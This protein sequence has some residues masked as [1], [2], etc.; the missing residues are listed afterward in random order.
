LLLNGAGNR[1]GRHF[2][3]PDRFD[4][5]RSV[6]RRLSFGYGAHFCVA[7]LARI[8]GQVALREMLR[9]FP[10]WEVDYD[11]AEMVHT[12]TVRGYARLPVRV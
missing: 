4:V 1:D 2:P 5:G 10:A 8:E 12:S 6:D 9:R 3:D 11:R 7:A